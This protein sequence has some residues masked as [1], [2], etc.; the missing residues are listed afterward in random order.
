M[1]GQVCKCSAST[2][3]TG[4]CTGS[5]STNYCAGNFPACGSPGGCTICGVES[6]R[7]VAGGCSCGPGGA[8]CAVGTCRDGGCQ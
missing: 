6:D 3:P 2:C 4:C 1:F 8:P 7:C 5:T